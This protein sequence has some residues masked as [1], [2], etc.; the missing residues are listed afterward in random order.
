MYPLVKTVLAAVLAY[1]T[2]YGVTKFYTGYC[3]PDGFWGFVQGSISAGSPLCSGAFT[4]MTQ[5]QTAYSTILITSLSH[6]FVDSM[7][8]VLEKK[9]TE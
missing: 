2:H 8:R 9:P 1:S 5:T 7:S 4:V 3:V 6:L